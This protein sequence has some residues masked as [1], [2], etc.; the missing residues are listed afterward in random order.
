M[1]IAAV[2]HDTGADRPEYP[3][4]LREAEVDLIRTRR[5]QV[6]D[7]TTPPDDLRELPSDTVGVALSGGGIRSATFC[8]GVFR[9]LAR[10]GVVRR[11]DVLSTVSGG[12]YFGAFLGALFSRPVC[13]RCATEGAS[14]PLGSGKAASRDCPRGRVWCVEDMLQ[15]LRSKPINWLRENG[16]YMSP[17]GSGDT[18]MAG[19]VLLRNWAALVVVVAALGVAAFA[20]LTLVLQRTLLGQ[21]LATPWTAATVPAF[22]VAFGA[23]PL[24]LAYWL[25]PLAARRGHGWVFASLGVLGALAVWGGRA[26]P[27][28]PGRPTAA[29]LLVSAGA[30]LAALA[31]ATWQRRR[32]QEGPKSP[33]VVLMR[34][35]LSRWLSLAVWSAVGLAVF[36]LADAAGRTVAEGPRTEIGRIYAVFASAGA[37]AAAA[38]GFAQKLLPYLGPFGEGRRLPLT[39]RLAIGVAA[40]LIGGAVVLGL[41][42][43]TH[44]LG[45]GHM[46]SLWVVGAGLTVAFGLA[47]PFVNLSSHSTLYSQRLT[48]AYLGASNPARHAGGTTISETLPGDGVAFA[49]YTPY[50]KG[51]PL[52]LVNV[53]LNETV[54]GTS[55]IEQ[56]DRKGRPLAIG[57]CGISVGRTDHARWSE[58][59]GYPAL[60][61][62]ADGPDGQGFRVFPASDTPFVAEGLHLGDWTSISGAA[63]TTGLGSRTSLA[64]SLLLGLANVR[65]GHW[66]DSGISPRARAGSRPGTFLRRWTSLALSRVQPVYFHLLAELLARFPGPAAKTWYLSDGGHFENTGAYELLRRRVPFILVCDAGC[67]PS[68]VFQDLANLVRKARTDFDAEVVF[69]DRGQLDALLPG[70]IRPYFGTQEDIRRLQVRPSTADAVQENPCPHALLAAVFYEDP[71]R[72]KR[73]PDSVMVILKPV[74]S[75]DEPPDV[76]DYRRSHPRFPQE[77]TSDQ[78]FDE[79]QWESYRRL[80]EHV[81]SRVFGFAGDDDG[82]GFWKPLNLTRPPA[83]LFPGTPRGRQG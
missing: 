23:I 51:G 9:A 4:L 83:V 78:F 24:A 12:G 2:S 41:A 28:W 32:Q 37:A 13:P 1:T 55:Q 33:V 14:G 22:I 15:N 56:R 40:V 31:F 10:I 71:A 68:Y 79:A 73:V 53:T 66:W 57:P 62:I 34:N 29:L 19:A 3:R 74:Y 5:R 8:L 16:R 77:P 48:R 35:R 30:W 76:V 72:V 45:R 65:L 60:S 21:Y 67:D 58:D 39:P 44:W 20:S 61:P 6:P 52:H 26:A 42:T 38:F 82:T 50:A 36:A 80:G 43:M 64:L 75:G 70:T 47:R 69:Y 63:F 27:G 18:L 46:F 7:G 54:S 17:N 11:I 25:T 49:E 81:A 59:G